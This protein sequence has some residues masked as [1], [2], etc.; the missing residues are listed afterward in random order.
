MK[1]TNTSADCLNWKIEE[2]WGV[3]RDQDLMLID[4]MILELITHNVANLSTIK[5]KARIELLM[6]VK[7]KL[8]EDWD[9]EQ[10]ET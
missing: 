3:S 6:D 10:K 5:I 7:A 2:N 4:Q 1:T 8:I 9:S